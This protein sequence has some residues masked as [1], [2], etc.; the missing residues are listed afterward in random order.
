[1]KQ[2]AEA[3]QAAAIALR[4]SSASTP[5]RQTGSIDSANLRRVKNF[6]TRMVEMYGPKWTSQAGEKPTELWSKAVSALSDDQVRTALGKCIKSGDRWPPSLPE[7]L[8][9]ARG[10]KREN[11]QAY[12]YAPMLPTPVS[13][14]ETAAAKLAEARKALR[15]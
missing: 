14:K 5:T 6:W 7:F 15:R 9:L 1:M 4:S 12:R 11:W 2:A 8:T 10:E 3:A 13:S